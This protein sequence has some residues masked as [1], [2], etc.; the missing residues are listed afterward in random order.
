S[1]D[2]LADF[3]N[4]PHAMGSL[5]FTIPAV[6]VGWI[7]LKVSGVSEKIVVSGMILL[8]IIL[9]I[10]FIIGLGLETEKIFYTDFKFAI[11]VFSLAIF[12]FIAQYTVPALARGYATK[13][14]VKNLPKAIILGMLLTAVLLMLVPMAAL[15]VLGPENVTEVITVAWADALGE[16]AFFVANGFALVAMMTSYWA[17]GESYLTNIVDMFKVPSEWS[18]KHRVIAIVCVAVPPFILAYSGLVGFVDA[19]SIA[20]SFAG[21]VMAFVPVT[22]I[23]KARKVNEQTPL[24]TCGR[25]AHPIIQTILIV[26]FVG[27]AVYTLLG[28]LNVLPKGW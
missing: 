7:G 15:G 16:W 17:I 14:N 18:I 11:P 6:G 2:I 8:I 28:L 25:L 26:V 21:A 24:W 12:A 27:A 13:E 23:N 1:G 5:L 19:L 10:V 3:L 9:V 4:I 22:M 20:C